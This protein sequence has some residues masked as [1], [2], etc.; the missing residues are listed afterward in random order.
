MQGFLKETIWNKNEKTTEKLFQ[1]VQFYSRYFPMGNSSADTRGR[2]YWYG[3]LG[4]SE[5]TSDPGVFKTHQSFPPSTPLKG[6]IYFTIDTNAFTIGYFE[7]YFSLFF[8]KFF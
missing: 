1:L 8:K 7:P 3:C 4:Q 6:M 5:I 2:K